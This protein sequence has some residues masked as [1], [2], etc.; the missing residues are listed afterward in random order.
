MRSLLWR[1][2]VLA[3][4]TENTSGSG[5][6]SSPFKKAREEAGLATAAL[7]QVHSG[8]RYPAISTARQSVPYV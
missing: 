4:E 6:D 1:C 8:L 3:R 2:W 7:L 5:D